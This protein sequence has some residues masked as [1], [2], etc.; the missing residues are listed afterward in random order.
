MASLNMGV[1]YALTEEEINA[2][3][4]PN[5]IGNYAFGYL[6]DRGVF[7]VKYVGRSDTDLRTRIKHGIADRE[8]D[9]AMYRY[10]RFKFS[11]ADTPEEAYKKECKNYQDF[12]GDKGKLIND[13]YPQ[14]P[15]YDET[16]SSSSGM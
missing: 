10:E 7:I 16:S 5:R 4:E 6:N 8:T 15:D 1:S 11:Y 12:G 13:R 2:N 9:P 3:I 14:A